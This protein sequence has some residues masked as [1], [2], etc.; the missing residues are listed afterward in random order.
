MFI[1]NKKYILQWMLVFAIGL[2]VKQDL[3]SKSAVGQKQPQLVQPQTQV[4]QA[5][6]ER[7]DEVAITRIQ[8][9]QAIQSSTSTNRFTQIEAYFQVPKLRELVTKTFK[10]DFAVVQYMDIV[11]R[12]MAKEAEFRNTHWAFYHG[13]TN[14]WTVPQDIYT[15]LYNHFNPSAQREGE[16]F[17][18]LRF[19]SMKGNTPKNFLIGELREHGLVDDNK[20]AKGLLLSTNFTPFG[21][22]DFKGE[23]TWRYFV[24]SQS[25]VYP[26]RE[27][28]EQIM[29][30]FNLPHTHIDELMSLT[31]ELRSRQQTL[32]QIFIPKDLVDNIGY[33]A[34]ATGI[35]AHEETINWVRNN[36]KRRGHNPARGKRV[37]NELAALK[38]QFK[39][40]QEKNPLFKDMLEKVE[41]GEDYSI[42]SYLKD[43]CNT[44]EK[45]PDLNYIQ[46]RL[47]FS[48]EI[49]LNPASGIKMFRHDEINYHKMKN[50]EKRL[51][52]IIQKIIAT[53]GKK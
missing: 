39:Q 16:D 27:I 50:Y 15:K 47:I 25:H 8:K 34:W 40:T 33:L 51:D 10:G 48:D 35:P 20:E 30:T 13:I 1:K 46:A 19:S 44:P 24:E 52:E 49:L 32:L 43:Y 2:L 42:D 23:S 37:L 12:M 3:W 45:L 18:F 9:E 11:S 17:I 28:Y 6:E 36:I 14:A 26:E 38:N 22:T 7:A 31:K 29:N 21:N 41:K 53:K 4:R 5:Q